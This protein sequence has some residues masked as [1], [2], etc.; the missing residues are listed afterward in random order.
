MKKSQSNNMQNFNSSPDKNQKHNTSN[1]NKLLE[2]L[3]M[4]K[5][6]DRSI[7]LNLFT[8]IC[9]K[10]KDQKSCPLGDQCMKSHS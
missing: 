6:F 2:T 8:E 5:D 3:M 4:E 9:E 10:S 7:I 1:N